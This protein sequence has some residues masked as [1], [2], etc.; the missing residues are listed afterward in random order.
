[1]TSTSSTTRAPTPAC[2]A[3]AGATTR[4]RPAS[5]PTT[6]AT[7][8]SFYYYSRLDIHLADGGVF[9]CEDLRDGCPGWSTNDGYPGN[10]SYLAIDTSPDSKTGPG[11]SLRASN[12]AKG[13]AGNG[14]TACT[15]REATTFKIKSDDRWPITKV[16]VYVN[17][18]WVK[19]KRGR[20]IKSVV[21]P[22]SPGRSRYL[23]RLWEYGDKGKD[24]DV[25]TRHVYGCARR[26]AA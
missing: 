7:R 25:V 18:R 12:T 16:K 17:H 26:R 15:A 5:I 11:A 6:T 19:T 9:D 1:M 10:Y 8:F 4:S 3:S 2:S 13:G 20:S 23:V 24:R 14:L 22:G 21:L